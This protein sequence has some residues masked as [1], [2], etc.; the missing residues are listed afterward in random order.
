M[1]LSN[2][3]LVA[4][5]IAFASASPAPAPEPTTP[6]ASQTQALVDDLQSYI[7]DLATQPIVSS[8]AT[9]TAALSSLEALQE[10][11]LSDVRDGETPNTSVLTALPSPLASFIGSIYTAE[12]SIASKNGFGDLIA[13]ETATATEA[14]SASAT[15]A[16]Q[17]ASGTQKTSTTG[18][19][20]ATAGSASA[21]AS[22]PVTNE[23]GAAGALGVDMLKICGGLAVGL[24]GAVMAL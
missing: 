9:D 14:A 16:S 4:G 17:T 11:L 15:G 10:S 19:A 22:A 1:H 8:L 2:S 6:S 18:S 12:I 3:L 20:S 5:L 24:V 13:S 23:T 21:S 7:L